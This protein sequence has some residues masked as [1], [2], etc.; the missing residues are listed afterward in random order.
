MILCNYGILTTGFDAP[1]TSA[2]V[3]ARPTKSYVL[4]AQMVGRGIRG[5]KAGGN[6]TCEISTVIDSNINDF[7]DITEVFYTVGGF[8]E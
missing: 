4:Y 7:I 2:I 3:I 1:Q 5:I 8:M 6:K